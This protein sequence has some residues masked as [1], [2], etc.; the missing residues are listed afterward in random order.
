MSEAPTASSAPFETISEAREAVLEAMAR[1]TGLG[2]AAKARP[3]V[4]AAQ[5]QK[6]AATHSYHSVTFDFFIH[7]FWQINA[8]LICLLLQKI[9]IINILTLVS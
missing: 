7:I 2:E 5:C 9:K 6:L 1:E 4:V 3:V 8:V